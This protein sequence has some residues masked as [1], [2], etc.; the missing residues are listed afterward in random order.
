MHISDYQKVTAYCHTKS[1][2]AGIHQEL[3]S[4]CSII[5]II[6]LIVTVAAILTELSLRQH[7]TICKAQH[8]RQS[9]S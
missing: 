3:L 6:A 4:L 7:R 9:F 2:E 8:T 1:H 5:V